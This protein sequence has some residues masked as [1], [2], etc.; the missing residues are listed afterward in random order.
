M[1]IIR[2]SERRDSEKQTS[3]IFRSIKILISF[4][5]LGVMLFWIYYVITNQKRDITNQKMICNKYRNMDFKGVIREVKRNYKMKLDI[6]L[7]DNDSSVY[8][9]WYYGNSFLEKGDSIVKEAGKSEYIIY[10]KNYPD[11]ILV[12]KFPH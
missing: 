11:S 9:M 12:L 8:T 3:P 6:F 7:F 1:Q 5:L 2:K 10:K 4:L